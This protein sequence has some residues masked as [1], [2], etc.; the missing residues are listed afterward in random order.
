[1]FYL[2]LVIVAIWMDAN[3]TLIP[4]EKTPPTTNFHGCSIDTCDKDFCARQGKTK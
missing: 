3:K 1:M 2:P 4:T